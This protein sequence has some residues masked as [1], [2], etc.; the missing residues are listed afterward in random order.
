MSAADVAT[1]MNALAALIWPM[2][3]VVAVMLVLPALRDVVHREKFS[4]KIGSFELS[5]QQ[6]TDQ[7]ARQIEDL[8]KTVAALEARTEA[9]DLLSF[10]FGV[11]GD[12]PKP[13][14]AAPPAAG[15]A[16]GSRPALRILW[17]DDNPANNAFEAG[18]LRHAGHDI[19]TA[20]TT[21][22]ALKAIADDGADLVISDI[23][24]TEGGRTVRDAGLRLLRTLRE[25]GEAIP[26]A[27]YASARGVRQH[28]EA[29]ARL[30]AIAITDSFVELQAA[31]RRHVI[32]R[33]S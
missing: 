24:R 31:I 16:H 20:V 22:E 28:G 4:I 25:S 10:D 7:L 5:A 1:L 13:G 6:A 19:A 26:F 17:V 9:R 11:S 27:I 32:E 3:A 18:A 21:E 8:Q 2:M 12:G 23:A 14:G 30:G 29:A 33:A 15:S